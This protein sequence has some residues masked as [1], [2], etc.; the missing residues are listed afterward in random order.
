MILFKG[1][2]KEFK[3]YKIGKS[4]AKDIKMIDFTRLMKGKELCLK[5]NGTK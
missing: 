2:R 3:R 5:Q 1:T 4:Y